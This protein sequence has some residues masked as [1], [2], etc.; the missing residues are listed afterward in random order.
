AGST[1]QESERPVDLVGVKWVSV[2]KDAKQSAFLGTHNFREIAKEYAGEFYNRWV[3]NRNISPCI[4]VR[5][6]LPKMPFLGLTLGMCADFYNRIKPSDMANELPPSVAFSLPHRLMHFNAI[7]GPVDYIYDVGESCGHSIYVD[8]ASFSEPLFH[9]F[10]AT[11]NHLLGAGNW[12][13]LV[14]YYVYRDSPDVTFVDRPLCILPLSPSVVH[15]LDRTLGPFSI[16]ID[17]NS[18]ETY[19]GIDLGSDLMT[20]KGKIANFSSAWFSHWLG[21]QGILHGRITVSS[22]ITCTSIFLLCMCY[23]RNASAYTSIYRKRHIT[24]E[25]GGNFSFPLDSP[26]SSAPTRYV[27]T[28]D[29]SSGCELYV[30]T[31]CGPIAPADSVTKLEYFLHFDRLEG[32]M[33]APNL[34]AEIGSLWCRVTSFLKEDVDIPIRARIY[35]I[36]AKDC[37]LELATNPFSKMIAATGFLEGQVT[38]SV[39]WSTNVE[40]SKIKGHIIFV[41]YD[42]DLV[43]SFDGASTVVPM[44]KGSFKCLLNCKTSARGT[45][46]ADPSLLTAW[47]MIKVHHAKDI[48]ELRVNVIPQTG[49]KFYGRS[50]EAIKVP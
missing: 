34:V 39:S 19:H 17:A 28:A 3:Y 29:S 37:T 25:G 20:D 23:K 26:F 8:S 5:C 6:H 27:S 11:S 32:T 50:A 30:D 1:Q 31:I 16:S 22:P 43:N 14:E 4:L 18:H 44:A 24:L 38:L 15:N 13:F 12:R 21:F 41:V 7:D 47:M 33:T 48:Q 42:A 46:S 36:A 45:T 40:A 10:C 35:D 2:P 49:F 9:F